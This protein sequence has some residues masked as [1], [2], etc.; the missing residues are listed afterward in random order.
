MLQNLIHLNPYRCVPKVHDHL[1][2]FKMLSTTKIEEKNMYKM[3]SNKFK[4]TAVIKFN[5]H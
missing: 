4:N 5:I 3:L 2:C 1:V